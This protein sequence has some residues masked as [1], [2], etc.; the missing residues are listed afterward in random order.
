MLRKNWRSE[1]AFLRKM[2][3]KLTLANTLPAQECRDAILVIEA[4][5]LARAEQIQQATTKNV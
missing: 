1:A 3:T 4:Q 5:L 2:A